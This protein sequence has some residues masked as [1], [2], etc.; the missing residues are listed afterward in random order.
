MLLTDTGAFAALERHW[1]L[2]WDG[3]EIVVELG[4]DAVRLLVSDEVLDEDV[5][6]SVEQTSWLGGSATWRESTHAIEAVIGSAGQ[7]HVC[8]LW[9]DGRPVGEN[10]PLRLRSPEPQQWAVTRRRAWLRLLAR[11]VV[12]PRVVLVGAV[13]GGL[14]VVG[15]SPPGRGLTAAVVILGLCA[16]WLADDVWQHSDLPHQR[17]NAHLQGQHVLSEP[18]TRFERGC[19]SAVFA[20]GALFSVLAALAAVDF[21]CEAATRGRAVFAAAAIVAGVLAAWALRVAQ[22]VRKP[23]LSSA[24]THSR[25]KVLAE[26]RWRAERIK[27]EAVAARLAAMPPIEG[28]HV[29]EGP[30]RRRLCF[31]QGLTGDAFAQLLAWLM[32]ADIEFALFDPL[33]PSPSDPGAYL[34]YRPVNGVWRMTLGNHGWTGGIYEI[35]MAIVCQQLSNLH[36]KGQLGE[37]TVEEVAFFSHYELRSVEANAEMNQRLCDIHGAPPR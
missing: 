33:Y 25:Q 23:S 34:S 10:H 17:R 28:I 7:S 4:A 22:R 6:W 29:Q 30:P 12:Q 9:V 5:R 37:I 13:L 32:Q 21:L 26:M 24:S 19:G 20:V 31:D 3:V 27:E 14:V 2:P 18:A 15:T 35:E 36:A 16:W 11:Y 8:K 1:S